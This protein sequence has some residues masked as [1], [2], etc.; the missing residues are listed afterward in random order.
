MNRQEYEERMKDSKYKELEITNC[1]S[2][3]E[4]VFI[5]YRGSSWRN[6]LT[7]IV[8]RLQKQY[9]LRIYFDKEFASETNV[10]IDQ[11]IRNMNSKNC[12]AVLC[13]FDEGYVTSYATLLELMHAM[14]PQSKLKNSIYSINFPIDWEKLNNE[15]DNTGLGVQNQDNP[16]WKKELAAFKYE[17]NLLKKQPEYDEISAYYSDLSSELRACDC[18]DIMSIIQP[19]NKRDYSDSDDFYMQFII[20]PLKKACPGVF[21]C[22][23]NKI[24]YKVRFINRSN[25]FEKKVRLGEKIDIPQVVD[26][27]GYNF[28]GWF[29]S[30][31][32]AERKWDFESDVVESDIE[33]IAKWEHVSSK[34]ETISLNDFLKIY[35]NDNFKKGTFTK[36]RLVGEADNSKFST[37][38][39]DSA[40]DL[41]WAFVMSLLAER[42]ISYIDEV[43]R[44]HTGMKNP[45]FITTDIYNIR[46]DQNKYRQITVAGLENFYMYRHYGQYDWI[47]VVLKQR[48]TE[49]GLQIK[50][51]KFEYVIKED[52]NTFSTL[53]VKSMGKEKSDTTLK[54]III[55]PVIAL[56]SSDVF[57]YVLWNNI[58]TAKSLADMMHDVFDLIAEKYPTHVVDMANNASITSVAL[59]SDVDEKKLPPN[60]L[61]YFTAKKEHVV[62][63]ITY[64]VS[65]KY[66]REQGVGQLEKML[67]LCEGNSEGFNIVSAPDKST[68]NCSGKKGIGEL[69]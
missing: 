61:N 8:Y 25:V 3:K 35:S 41:A 47:S 5:S 68:H 7:N 62:G 23:K 69:L 57:E 64:Y 6:V 15:D 56:S 55:K 67:T 60:K 58:H 20:N 18:K 63:G 11:F 12:K 54:G 27:D 53:N 26:V 33:L 51:F 59:K 29:Y 46:S 4:Y 19:Q 39:Y 44:M 65:T 34:Y 48:L 16:A 49:Y 42:G 24:E 14:N 43:N 50:D 30:A 45:V 13:F 40:F 66:N 21:E 38:F 1:D 10:W 52:S 28:C 22:K 2:G 37:D 36:F 17:F 9:N 32:G 31:F